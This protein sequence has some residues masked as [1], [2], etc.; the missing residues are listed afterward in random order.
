MSDYDDIG[1]EPALRAI[2]EDFIGRVEQDFVIGFFFQGRDLSRIRDKEFELASAHLGGPHHYTGRPLGQVHD[3]LP[4]NKGHLQRRLAFLRTVL[5][6]HGVSDDVAER[7]V[8]H[9][10]RLE[11]LITNGRDCNE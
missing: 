4:I 1:G 7:W 5:R 6:D 11:D 8:A 2:V 10:A 9:D 3:K